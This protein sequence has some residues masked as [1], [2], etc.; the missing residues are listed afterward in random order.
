METEENLCMGRGRPE[1]AGCDDSDGRRTQWGRRRHP[2][3]MGDGSTCPGPQP[4]G[5]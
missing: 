3:E 1:R 4:A 2:D 5:S